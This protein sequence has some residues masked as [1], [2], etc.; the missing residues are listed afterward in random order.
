METPGDITG[1]QRVS[2]RPSLI[3]ATDD[4]DMTTLR[5]TLVIYVGYIVLTLVFRDLPIWIAA[6]LCAVWLAWHASLQHETIHGH[7]TSSRRL[8][9]AL[10]SPPLSLWIPYRI[11]RST[12]L[13]HHRHGG[14]HL[15]E[16]SRDPESFF[17]RPGT[18]SSSGP[19]LR[20]V[21]FANCTL[22]G[23]L[24][25][26]PALAAFRFWAAEM[27][28]ARAGHR[29]CRMIWARHAIAVA[30]VLLWTTV[31]CHIPVAVYVMFVVYPS[32]SLSQLRSFV[33]HRADPEP[34]LRTTAVEAHPVWAL[35]FLN[36]NLHIAHHAHPTLPWH[37]LPS[38]W[39]Q[40]RDSA[41][42]S[43]LV[44]HRGYRQV[45]Q[46]YL[47]RPVISVEHPAKDG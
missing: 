26:G 16:F 3:S 33:E 9:S 13:Q 11:Y 43:G 21:F 19:F 30:L 36:N 41:M 5:L 18:V 25:L 28:K 35:I 40:M 23:R 42:G 39:S 31:V 22:V 38:A 17:M 4:L 10:A 37:Q 1:S 8:N 20:A 46:S 45:A 6:P 7:P 12:H 32:I 34:S 27:R 2:S 14:R 24:V 15:T 47:F 44:F 29:D